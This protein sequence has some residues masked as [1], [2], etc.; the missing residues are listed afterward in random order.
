MMSEEKDLALR[1]KR[2]VIAG[3]RK[4]NEISAIIEKQGGVP[5]VRP[6]QGTTVLANDVSAAQLKDLASAGADWCVFTTGMGLDALLDQAESLGIR[7]QLLTIIRESKVA[8]RG[9]KTFAALKRIDVAPDVEDHDGTVR[10]LIDALADEDFKGKHVALQL[11]GEPM[12]EWVDYLVERGA[13][14][15]ILTPYEHI[16]PEADVVEQLCQEIREQ[17]LDA[18]CFTTALQVRYLYA[19]LKE[20]GREEE[21]LAALRG[22]VVAVA[23]GKVTEAALRDI[24]VDRIVAP[25]NERMG[26]MIIALAHYY[27]GSDK[28]G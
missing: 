8:A 20:S 18:I 23:V 15:H 13:N 1:N 28:V 14:V 26:A 27:A 10:S 4:G 2:V 24:G 21:L 22:P 3:A 7:E 17:S 25:D 9:Y 16:P 19:Y 6:L 11:H 5:L 12:P